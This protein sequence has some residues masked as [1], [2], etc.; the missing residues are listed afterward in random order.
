[1]KSVIVNSILAISAMTVAPFANAAASRIQL[2]LSDEKVID[3]KTGEKLCFYKAE[4]NL[5][6][7]KSSKPYQ[8]MKE[9]EP[10][11]FEE[12]RNS[13][14]LS[15]NEQGHFILKITGSGVAN[16]GTTCASQEILLLN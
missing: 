2:P 13:H 7:S 3:E 4:I 16:K 10:N 6:D 12:M 8:V 14:S 5:G 11:K 9:T 15:I 1:M